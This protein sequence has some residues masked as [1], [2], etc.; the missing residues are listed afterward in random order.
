MVDQAP[1]QACMN[2]WL[3][4]AVSAAHSSAQRIVRPR[5]LRMLGIT[6]PAQVV[7][8]AWRQEERRRQHGSARA[9]L[10]ATLVGDRGDAVQ[11]RHPTG[12]QG[13]V[14]GH[15]ERRPEER[16][17]EVLPEKVRDGLVAGVFKSATA[18]VT[19]F[20]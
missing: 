1:P 12:R 18:Q 7:E 16:R 2:S 10:V 20:R 15:A 3:M 19:Q 13:D 4:A 9:A 17:P 11:L 8:A 6:A 5:A 14:E